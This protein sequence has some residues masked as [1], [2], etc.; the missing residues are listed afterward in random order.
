VGYGCW[1]SLLFL[2]N[3]FAYAN[4]YFL[5][6]SIL[7]VAILTQSGADRCNRD[8]P[9]QSATGDDQVTLSDGQ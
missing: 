9:G 7:L 8:A 5:S 4:Y 2:F 3:R 6:A 1:Y